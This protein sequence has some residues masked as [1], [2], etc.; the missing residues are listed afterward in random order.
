VEVENKLGPNSEQAAGF[1]ESGPDGPI[2]MVNLLKFKEQAEYEDGRETKLTGSE[3]YDLYADEV[4]KLLVEFGGA[5]MFWAPVERLT[6]GEVEDLWDVVAIA[7]Y[8]SRGAMMAMARSEKMR[9]IGVHRTAG[10]A[11]QL[12]I[13]SAYATGDWLGTD[14]GS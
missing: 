5:F 14:T 9:E 12:N 7:M 2:Y 8:P 11:G 4:K 1:L 13:E 3:A 10:L 6:L